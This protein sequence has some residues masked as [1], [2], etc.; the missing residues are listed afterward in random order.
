MKILIIVAGIAI[1]GT[2]GFRLYQCGQCE[3]N[4]SCTD[5]WNEVVKCKNGHP[6]KCGPK[7]IS[8]GDP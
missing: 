2:G 8:P 1:A 6:Y 4:V 5:H 3:M 7:P